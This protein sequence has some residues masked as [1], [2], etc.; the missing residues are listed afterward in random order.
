MLRY[1]IRADHDDYST[2]I[3]WE[4]GLTLVR[5]STTGNNVKWQI[6]SVRIREFTATGS[7]QN[8][9]LDSAPVVKTSDG[10]WTVTHAN[11]SNPVRAEFATV[12]AFD[13][14]ATVTTGNAADLD[15]TISSGV[16][17]Q[18]PS[19]FPAG[20]IV[21]FWVWNWTQVGSATPDDEGTDEPVVL[22]NDGTPI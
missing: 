4:V 16:V 5:K 14:T 2:P 10:Y 12:P 19:G 15:Y 8:N 22:E 17:G 1:S 13:G 9:W 20:L 18:Y 7:V 6:K 11:P 21:C 3:K